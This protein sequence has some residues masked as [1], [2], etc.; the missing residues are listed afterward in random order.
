MRPG[1]AQIVVAT[2]P[3]RCARRGEPTRRNTLRT[4]GSPR[5]VGPIG[6][7]ALCSRQ[8]AALSTHARML[9][10]AACCGLTSPTS[11]GLD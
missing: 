3:N 4:N 5:R 6:P 1:A 10:G 8:S 7:I 11:R 2:R 9:A